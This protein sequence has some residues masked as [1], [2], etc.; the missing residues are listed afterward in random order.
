MTDWRSGPGPF[1]SGIAGITVMGGAL[2]WLG[3]AGAAAAASA[4]GLEPARRF[5]EEGRIPVPLH[6]GAL[7][8]A[9]AWGSERIFGGVAGARAPGLLLGTLTIVLVALLARRLSSSDQAAQLAAL[10]VAV[11]P[12]HVALSRGGA[13]EVHAAFF[14]LAGVAVVLKHLDGGRSA[15]AIVAGALLGLALSAS[16]LVAAP[17]GVVVVY[18]AATRLSDRR[19]GAA[20]RA[21][22][23]L[24]IAAALLAVPLAIYFATYAP[25]FVRGGASLADWLWLP[26]R[27]RA[28]LGGAGVG[29]PVAVDVSPLLWFVQPWHGGRSSPLSWLATLPAFAALCWR[30]VDRREESVLLTLGLLC[31]AY[32]PFVAMGSRAAFQGAAMVLPFAW[33]VVAWSVD[34]AASR[35]R[36]GKWLA[37]TYAAAVAATAVPLCLR[38]PLR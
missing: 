4:A 2:R 25:A 3:F 31:C 28:A 6:T 21:A 38:A 1:A 36:R 9:L 24:F 26:A 27:G 7:P 20:V 22:E 10:L 35:L 11:D 14:L 19:A 37:W 16:L 32:A 13:V 30:V 34:S 17:I 12:L 15:A 8:L 18:A 33:V 29:N 23:G 5:V